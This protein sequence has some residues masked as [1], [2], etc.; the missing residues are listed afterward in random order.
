LKNLRCQLKREI[1][2]KEQFEQKQDE[3]EKEILALEQKKPK[4]NHKIGSVNQHML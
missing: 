2:A 1:K 3:T 4:I